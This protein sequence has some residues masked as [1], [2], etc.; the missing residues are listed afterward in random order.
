ML[1]DNKKNTKTKP[2]LFFLTGIALTVLGFLLHQ[3][4]FP[5]KQSEPVSDYIEP[6]QQETV[7]IP[8]A[9][10]LENDS[11]APTATQQATPT[12]IFVPVNIEIDIDEDMN[13]V[14]VLAFA[15]MDGLHQHIFIY[16]PQFFPLTRLTNS[17]WDDTDP[18][19][20]HDGTKLAYASIQNG[21]WDIYILDLQTY[22]LT[23]FT[24]TE[25][26]ESHPSWSPDDQWLVF[27]SDRNGNLD[28]FIQSTTS[29]GDQPI[30]L[31]LSEAD[32]FHP[33]WSPDGRQIAYTSLES[34]NEDIWLAN[35]DTV[36]DRYQNISQQPESIELEPFW[37]PNND[38]LFWAGKQNLGQLIIQETDSA[39]EPTKK[40]VSGS[41]GTFHPQGDAMAVGFHSAEG[42]H[43]GVYD[44]TTGTMKFPFQSMPGRITGITWGN[45]NLELLLPLL[46]QSSASTSP[47]DW[48]Y[49]Q[50]SE[51]TIPGN[52][53]GLVALPGIDV[54][55][56][57]LHDEVDESFSSLRQTIAQ[58]LGWDFLQTLNNAFIPITQP[59]PP[60]IEDYW[61]YTARAFEIDDA[62]ATANWLVTIRE[63]IEG[64]T[65]W[66][67]YLKPIDQSGAVGEKLHQRAWSFDL[68]T[69]G[70]PEAYEQGGAYTQ[71]V[72][73]GYWVDFTEIAN[74]FGW[75][76]I[77]ALVN[78]R[79]YY[80]GTQHT[81]FVY[82]EYLDLESALL[83]IYPPEA[84]LPP[85]TDSLV[86]FRPTATPEESDE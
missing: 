14:G 75:S 8:V 79:T 31:T 64:K 4:L 32:D 42:S 38:Q 34:G 28:I 33:S 66:R 60:M 61:L 71:S 56:P 36:E 82:K 45:Q 78:W 23:N 72:P 2:I 11:P 35:L 5:Q 41:I 37:S 76:W 20:S 7:I 85:A 21:N 77:P 80:P 83:E 29:D 52:R 1:Q 63:D 51:S 48:Q 10:Q 6:I 17:L 69:Q 16:H 39:V 65:Y 86:P 24:D 57:Y 81:I 62:P 44:I 55:F 47:A 25:S 54:E 18:A 22:Q 84:L 30:Q 49:V 59:A 3:Q 70:N 74:Q 9:T 50:D 12:S 13:E 40:I 73:E 53:M 15:M 26:Y 27:E 46:N 68:R 43:L 67:I 58:I 19:F